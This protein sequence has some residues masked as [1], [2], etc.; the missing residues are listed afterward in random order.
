MELDQ[1]HIYKTEKVPASRPVKGTLML[2][3]I[4]AHA[5]GGR[6]HFFGFVVKEVSE[7]FNLTDLV[8]C[9]IEWELP[10]RYKFELGDMSQLD[11]YS[12]LECHRSLLWRPERSTLHL[13]SLP[14]A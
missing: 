10:Q 7:I 8:Q 4:R 6:E 9:E 3:V 14:K 1:C 2:P 13:R 5:R 12:P 11:E